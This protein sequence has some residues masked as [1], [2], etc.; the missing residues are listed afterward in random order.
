MLICRLPY[1]RMSSAL[2]S[3]ALLC[4]SFALHASPHSL[5]L[6]ISQ[7]QTEISQPST[8]YQTKLTNQYGPSL[9]YAFQLADAWQLRLGVG[10]LP[11]RLENS[12][13]LVSV[14][15]DGSVEQSENTL[16]IRRRF[17][18]AMLEW[19]YPTAWQGLELG[20]SGGARFWQHQSTRRQTSEASSTDATAAAGFVQQSYSS[21]QWSWVGAGF[22]QY[23]LNAQ[24]SLQLSLNF[25]RSDVTYPNVVNGPAQRH[26]YQDQWLSLHFRH[27]F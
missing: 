9:G 2:L 17:A 4:S 24:D 20:V 11:K 7:T 26:Q 6:T 5:E 16:H 15:S 18:E 12:F 23:W 10:V 13:H 14:Q 19:H 3:A 21:N 1:A 27:Q 25:S 8:G 22:A